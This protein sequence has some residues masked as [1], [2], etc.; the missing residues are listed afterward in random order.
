MYNQPLKL[1]SMSETKPEIATNW[2]VITGVHE[3]GTRL[4]GNKLS[5]EGFTVVQDGAELQEARGIEARR[6]LGLSVPYKAGLKLLN[7]QVGLENGLVHPHRSTIIFVGGVGDS[8]ARIAL[9]ARN[10]EGI[11][12]AQAVAAYQH[13]WTT[14]YRSVFLLDEPIEG[15]TLPPVAR[16]VAV[17]FSKKL[18]EAY[19]ETLGYQPAIVENT[20][21]LE[22]ASKFVKDRITTH[23]RIS[24]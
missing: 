21:S 5:R 10:V 20:E 17:E 8:L 19:K 13:G 7:E 11:E 4:L 6:Q 9:S 12:E 14:R 24:P 15:L 22:A 3:Y 18:K 23:L 2:F 1:N 16:A